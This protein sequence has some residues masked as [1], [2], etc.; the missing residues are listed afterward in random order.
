MTIQTS[1][2]CQ[3]CGS[4]FA[5]WLGKCSVCDS[6]NSLV[7]SVKVT[8]KLKS[9]A[10]QSNRINSKTSS[11]IQKLSDIKP[12]ATQRISTKISELD[13][14]LGGGLVYGQVVL[15]AGEPGIGKSTLLI[16][17]SNM[18]GNCLY[19]SG[20][21]SASQVAIRAKRLGISNKEIDFLEETDVDSIISNLEQ[22]S[23]KKIKA[24]IVDSIQTMSTSD[25]TGLA[26]SVGQVKEC[27]FRL[28]RY[29]KSNNI[30]LILVGHVTKEGTV[31]GPAVLAHIVDTVLWFE[32]EKTSNLRL[33]R[34]VKNRFGATDEVGIF[35][36]EDKGLVSLNDPERLFLERSKTSVP[37]SV[38]SI[39]MEGSRSILVE[40][41][42]LVV[43]TK[44]AFPRRVAQGVDSK[45]LEMLLAVLFRRA[46]IPLY[47]N[48]VFVNIAGGIKANDPSVDLAICLSIASSFY[49]KPLP[50]DFVS[51]GEVGLLGEIRNV[52]FQDKR[53]KD[54]KRLG[55]E[56]VVSSKE[57][58]YLS[59]ILKEYFK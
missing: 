24:I 15:I 36:M 17:L 29:A 31:A 33:L 46:N 50:N 54:A 10:S 12:S 49:N 19:V 23:S 1:F 21:E 4:E 39:L 8:G 44:M 22:G 42:S 41:Q 6:W 25:L 32:G 9:K 47:D 26:G 59:Q 13:R 11:S 3:Q 20:E 40:V 30:P 28:L 16:Q 56:N 35:Q 57:H 34:S 58:K 43:P 18:L 51:V 52:P 14:C 2:V 5:K 7:E 37:G 55:F 45:R 27:A 38:V 48:D 53:I